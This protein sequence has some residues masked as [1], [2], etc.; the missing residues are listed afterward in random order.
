MW[1]RQDISLLREL[2]KYGLSI[3][4][5]K[6]RKSDGESRVTFADSP[7]DTNRERERE[8]EE[9]ERYLLYLIYIYI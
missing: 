6:I 9:R 5:Q 2:P 3:A 7:T 4:S 1:D 8:R